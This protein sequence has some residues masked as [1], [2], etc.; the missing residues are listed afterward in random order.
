M[1]L[2]RNVQL[3]ALTTLG[4]GGPAGELAVLDDICDFAQMASYARS[5]S[6]DPP[7]VIG[8]GSNILAADDGY[9]G[10]IIRM[11]A[12][13]TRFAGD[14]ASA[15]RV[16]VT[17]SAGHQLQALVDE[18]VAEGL[19]GIECLT[20]IPG[21]AG[22]TPVQNVGAYGQEIKDIA[23]M[24]R[25][26]DWHQHREVAFSPGQCQ[27]GH[28]TSI[29]K[30]SSRWTILAVTFTLTRSPLGP[31]LSY[32]AVAEAA[33]VP[34]GT[35]VP[36]ADTATAVRDVRAKKGM[37]LD[38]GDQDGRTAGSIFLSPA[39]T[40]TAATALRAAGA[41]VNDFPDG[42]VRV[43]A[44]WLIKTA[45]FRL[46]QHITTGCRISGKHYTIVA[47]DGA[48][49]ATFAAA[50]GHVAQRVRAATGITLTA[51][52]DLLGNLPAYSELAKTAGE[53]RLALNQ[54]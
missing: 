40:A 21:T 5:R 8:S 17:V 37:I 2:G 50:A 31:P 26:W 39:I 43:S 30:R 20:G 48:T 13:G 38:P 10:L 9:P 44:S 19:S 27:F 25:A 22:A 34:K 29:F 1:Q 4:L 49:A 7:R 42:S 6:A 46:G 11:A 15:S 32:S 3:A 33:G 14:P 52:P 18:T 54:L 41:P 47:N 45:G 23:T 28:R 16:L 53:Q 35:R 51:E 24:V 36:P 12:S